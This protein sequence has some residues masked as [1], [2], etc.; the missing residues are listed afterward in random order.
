LHGVDAEAG[1]GEDDEEDYDDNRDGD[2]FLDHFVRFVSRERSE[3][4]IYGVEVL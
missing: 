2:V 1:Q 4:Y 3:I